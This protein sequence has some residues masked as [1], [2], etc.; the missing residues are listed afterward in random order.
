MSRSHRRQLAF[1]PLEDR[2]L[3]AIVTVNT[4]IDEN[5]G[6]GNTSLRE[7]VATANSGDTIQFAPSV[8]GTIN[9]ASFGQIQI[10]K[11]LTIQGPGSSVLTVRAY[12]PDGSNNSNGARIFLVDGSGTLNV[13]ISGLTLTNGDPSDSDE[14]GGGGAIVNRENLTL[15]DC[16]LTGNYGPNGG[17]IYNLVGA[18]TINDSTISSNNAGDGAGI[19]VQ[20]GS[21][22]MNRSIVTGNQAS[23]AGA[24][25]M[26]TGPSVNITDS[27]VSLNIAAEAGGGLYMDSGTLTVTSSTLSQNTSSAASGGGIYNVSGSIS[28]L[29][30]TI[31]GNSADTNGGG[32]FSDTSST[33]SIKHSTITQNRVSSG[34]RGGGVETMESAAFNHTIVAN[35]FRGS[36]TSTHDDVHGPSTQT[37]S[38]IGVTDPKLAPL[39]NNGGLTMTHALL[40]D[41]P[42]LEAGAVATAGAGGVPL[43]DQRGTLFS[44]VVDFDNTGGAKLDIGAVEMPRPAPTLPGDYN[45]NHG[46]DAADYVMW[47]KTSGTSVSQ[48]YAGA[49]GN[50]DK[51]ITSLDYVVW[52]QAF[53]N[54]ESS[55]VSFSSEPIED[56]LHPTDRTEQVTLMPPSTTNDNLLKRGVFVDSHISAI[57]AAVELLLLEFRDS[58][59]LN[60]T[61]TDN[62]AS[63]PDS[64][65]GSGSLPRRGEGCE[66][67]IL[68]SQLESNSL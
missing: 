2:R 44:R 12:D 46:V 60:S 26:S 31:S 3:L 4:T 23:N 62:F 58:Q 7:A 11:N 8:T 63:R 32:I 37:F 29:N 34:S 68:C 25:I 54:A 9:L 30:S 53:G 56:N 24:G 36:G 50:G 22:T 40:A 6:T 45:L 52:R 66:G 33:I 48:P 28:I 51:N 38:L 21:L 5:N 10:S 57:D 67:G 16:V 27:T 17:A 49:D 39:A 42:A 20:G 43:Y 47:R 13:T 15:N 35:N 41:S 1:E 14:T 55:A 64:M 65:P 18:L 19:L 61:T 59:Q